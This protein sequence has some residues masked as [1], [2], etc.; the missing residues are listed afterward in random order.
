MGKMFLGQ[1]CEQ[2]RR[3]A[4]LRVGLN[5]IALFQEQIAVC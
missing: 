2:L 1:L 3:L 4:H 5:Y